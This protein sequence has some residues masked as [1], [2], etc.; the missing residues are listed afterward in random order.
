MSND[1]WLYAENKIHCIYSKKDE[2]IRKY[3]NSKIN[4]KMI[5]FLNTRHSSIFRTEFKMVIKS[6]VKLSPKMVTKSGVKL[7]PMMVTKSA[8]KLS[9]TMAIKSGAKRSP[10]MVTKSGAKLS[11]NMVTESVVKREI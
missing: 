1:N 9:P 8:V 4:V 2:T 6:G 11:P 10:N 3:S 7:S 5:Q